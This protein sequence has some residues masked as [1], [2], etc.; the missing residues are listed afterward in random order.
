MT[1]SVNRPHPNT[2]LVKY[3]LLA[4]LVGVLVLMLMDWVAKP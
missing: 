1:F 4:L 3:T 2:N